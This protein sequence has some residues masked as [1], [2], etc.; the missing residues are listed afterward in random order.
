MLKIP[1]YAEVEIIP[2]PSKLTSLKENSS[3][4]NYFKELKQLD[5]DHHPFGDPSGTFNEDLPEYRTL[6][7]NHELM[8][9]NYSEDDI[10]NA[11]GKINDC[12]HD[13]EF[14]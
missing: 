5:L 10:L 13:T 6:I 1:F 3:L 11:W 8:W 14:Y 2:I 9:K 12:Q 4:E 7:E